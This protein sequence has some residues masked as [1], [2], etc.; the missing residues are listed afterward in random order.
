MQSKRTQNE[1]NSIVSRGFPQ[2]GL[3]I[4]PVILDS[5]RLPESLSARVYFDLRKPNARRIRE[6]IDLLETR[7]KIDFSGL[8]YN[9]FDLMVGDLLK[10]LGFKNIKSRVRMGDIEADFTAEYSVKDPFGRE[11][12]ETWIVEN[13]F[14]HHERPTIR[15]IRD[16]ASKLLLF[17][18]PSYGLL[19]TNGQL[20]SV[21]RNWLERFE[22]RYG[23]RISVIDG[24]ELRELLMRY[25]TVARKYGFEGRAPK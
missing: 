22:M 24:P 21:A 16:F 10:E 3:V 19:V 5:T 7:S 9:A 20:T 23:T 13:K 8:D 6:L 25:P 11:S 1:F 17:D 4:L 12:V 2:K 14:Y 18:R 15:L